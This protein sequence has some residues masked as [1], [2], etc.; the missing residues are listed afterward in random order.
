MLQLLGGEETGDEQQEKQHLTQRR[1]DAEKTSPLLL[2]VS[3]SLY[4]KLLRF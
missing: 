2:C 3:V 1:S 4:Q